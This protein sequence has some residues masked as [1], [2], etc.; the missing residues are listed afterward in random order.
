[1]TSIKPCHPFNARYHQIIKGNGWYGQYE[2]GV[3]HQNENFE[4]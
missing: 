2:N 1:M 4:T 3:K